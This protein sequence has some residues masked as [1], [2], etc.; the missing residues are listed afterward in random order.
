MHTFREGEEFIDVSYNV[1]RNFVYLANLQKMTLYYLKFYHL[2]HNFLI[3][4]IIS[5]PNLNSIQ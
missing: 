4:V 3:I 2:S 1:N 5:K